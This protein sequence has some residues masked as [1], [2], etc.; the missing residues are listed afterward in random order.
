MTKKVPKLYSFKHGKIVKVFS[1]EQGAGDELECSVAKS[2]S[3]KAAKQSNQ[4]GPNWSVMCVHPY[5]E[6]EGQVGHLTTR[7]AAL[8]HFS[9][10][11]HHDCQVMWDENKF[12]Y[13]EFLKLSKKYLAARQA[14]VDVIET[15]D[16]I[17]NS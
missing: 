4:V 5:P 16:E 7:Q 3:K 17:E 11:I 8:Y 12:A 6:C 9:A 14:L 2:D 10:V 1:I 13:S 15:L